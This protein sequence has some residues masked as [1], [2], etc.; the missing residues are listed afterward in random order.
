MLQALNLLEPMDLKA[1]GY[2][3]ARYIHTLYQVMNLAFADRDF[4]YGDP[5]RPAGRAAARAALE[6]VRARRGPRGS[7]GRR[8]DANAK[9]GD[10]YPFQGETRIP[11]STL[12]EK[13]RTARPPPKASEAAAIV[14]DVPAR[15]LRRHDVDRSRGRG[16]MGRLG[17]AVGRLDSGRASRARRGS[18]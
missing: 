11:I 2:N 14:A 10:P 7:T 18:A 3:S 12:L 8:N 5:D 15:L 17:D 4:Y 6:G 9:P 16:G 1:M 13:W